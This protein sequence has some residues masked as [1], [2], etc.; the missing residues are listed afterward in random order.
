ML[1]LLFLKIIIFVQICS[2]SQL[3]IDP[4]WV[5]LVLIND[6][7]NNII[8]ILLKRCSNTLGA[9]NVVVSHY[10]DAP[11]AFVNLCPISYLVMNVPVNFLANYVIEKKGNFLNVNYIKFKIK[12]TH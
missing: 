2:L 9:I 4:Y 12:G 8:I 1:I 3:R 7:N 6:D 5:P 10:Y 11:I